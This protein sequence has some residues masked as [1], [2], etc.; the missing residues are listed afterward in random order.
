MNSEV[1]LDSDIEALP[2]P[3]GSVAADANG[4]RSNRRR[5]PPHTE[6]AMWGYDET[7]ERARYT[8]IKARLIRLEAALF[9][10]WGVRID[11]SSREC[12]LRLFVA[13]PSVR[14]P[15]I[16]SS[17]DGILT[18]TWRRDDGQELVIRCISQNVVHF[19][20][21]SRS[22]ADPQHM[23]RQW[24]TS[25]SPSLFFTETEKARVIAL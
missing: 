7:A 19:A 4:R 9:E 24:G 15:L 3:A 13:Y 1:T 20:I 25:H 18:A 11:R 2:S 5:P 12:I 23:D 17:P 8:T 21:V 10:E 16:T 22:Q 14:V 6:S